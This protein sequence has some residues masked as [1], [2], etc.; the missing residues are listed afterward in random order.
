MVYNPTHQHVAHLAMCLM[1]QLFIRDAMRESL[2][3]S[4]ISDL[5][6]EAVEIGALSDD[7][8]L[9]VRIKADLVTCIVDKKYPTEHLERQLAEL[10]VDV[11]QITFGG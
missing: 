10:G 11:N 5:R 3:L 1:T 7:E 2:M 6:D 8:A 9:H 4:S